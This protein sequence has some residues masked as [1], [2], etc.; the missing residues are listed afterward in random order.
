MTGHGSESASW[1]ITEAFARLATILDRRRRPD[2]PGFAKGGVADFQ[3]ALDGR[4]VAAFLRPGEPVFTPSGRV[5]G[6]WT[7]AERDAVL[8]NGF[9]RRW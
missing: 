6:W 9:V 1:G 5:R 7:D 8:A 4:E 2:V 3:I